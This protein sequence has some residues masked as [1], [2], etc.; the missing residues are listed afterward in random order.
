VKRAPALVLAVSV[1]LVC[2]RAAVSP[3][4]PKVP[5]EGAHGTTRDADALA[6][7][8]RFTVFVFYADHCPCMAAH[9]PRLFDLFARYAPRGVAMYAVDSEVTATPERD[10]A[11]ARRRAYPFPIMVDRGARLAESLGADY[12]AYAVVVD[13][14]GRVHYRGGI[15]SD[16]SHLRDVPATYLADALDDLLAGK[17]P[18]RPEAKTLGCALMLR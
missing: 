18:R 17:E 2:S 15:D 5:L 10:D 9:E 13:A 7:G 3:V 4:V 6:R 16:R 1:A 11:E 12:A 14:S 8:S